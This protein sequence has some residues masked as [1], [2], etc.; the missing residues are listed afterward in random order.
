MGAGGLRLRWLGRA[1]RANR[2]DVAAKWGFA[3]RELRATEKPK[4][5]RNLSGE[6]GNLSTRYFAETRSACGASKPI[7]ARK[8]GRST[9]GEPRFCG[10]IG[11]IRASVLGEMGP[12]L[13]VEHSRL[14]GEEGHKLLGSVRAALL[15]VRTAPVLSTS[16][17]RTT[18]LR[19]SASSAASSGGGTSDLKR[20]RSGGPGSSRSPLPCVCWSGARTSWGRGHTRPGA[21]RA[22]Y[23][24]GECPH[25]DEKSDLHAGFSRVSLCRERNAW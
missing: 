12:L 2:G 22:P 1:V 18:R 6:N 3:Y 13:P 7:Q 10:S 20:G 15:Q 11:R 21:L 23:G 16:S 25:L 5:A 9:V 8:G 17:I 4:W 19:P 24:A 14:L